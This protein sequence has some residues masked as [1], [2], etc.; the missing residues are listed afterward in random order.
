[1]S[2]KPGHFSAEKESW[3]MGGYELSGS[4]FDALL[5]KG[6]YFVAE[7][8]TYG[9]FIIPSRPIAGR[10]YDEDTLRNLPLAERDRVAERR[11]LNSLN[12]YRSLTIWN[13][14]LNPPD[15]AVS[16]EDVLKITQASINQINKWLGM[17]MPEKAQQTIEK[18]SIDELNLPSEYLDGTETLTRGVIEA[19]VEE[20]ENETFTRYEDRNADDVDNLIADLGDEYARDLIVSGIGPDEMERFLR[21]NLFYNWEI[22]PKNNKAN[23]V[24]IPA[25]AGTDL[26]VMRSTGF[27]VLRRV[28]ENLDSNA[29][30][31]TH[32]DIF[33]AALNAGIDNNRISPYVRSALMMDQADVSDA[34]KQNEAQIILDYLGISPRIAATTLGTA[35][36]VEIVDMIGDR[37]TSDFNENLKPYID[38]IRISGNTDTLLANLATVTIA[39]EGMER[40]PSD[41]YPILGAGYVIDQDIYDAFQDSNWN[42]NESIS[43]NLNR[44]VK[45]TSVSVNG[46]STVFNLSKDINW[47]PFMEGDRYTRK[48]I[49][50]QARKAQDEI[51]S[52][53]SKTDAGQNYTVNLAEEGTSVKD[54]YEAFREWINAI[55]EN[56]EN[57]VA[58]LQDNLQGTESMD[59]KEKISDST[60]GWQNRKAYAVEYFSRIEDI[61]DGGGPL[62]ADIEAISSFA[63]MDNYNSFQEMLN[64]AAFEEAVIEAWKKN[65]YE[66]PIDP[67]DYD[68]RVKRQELLDD[69]VNNELANTFDGSWAAWQNVEEEDKEDLYALMYENRYGSRREALDDP[70]FIAAAQTMISR[71]ASK[72]ATTQAEKFVS[73]I[74]PNIEARFRE[75]GII[76]ANTSPEFYDFL[77]SNVIPDIA[78]QAEIAGISDNTSLE[79]LIS[80]T[81]GSSP[82]EYNA[83]MARMDPSGPPT[84]PG[85]QGDAPSRRVPEPEPAPA[86]DLRGMTPALL[87]IAEERPEYATWLQ[88]QMQGQE[89]QQAWDAASRPARTFDEEQYEEEMGLSDEERAAGI[90]APG[91]GIDYMATFPG[92]PGQI[93]S[94]WVTDEE[95][96]AEAPPVEYPEFEGR[97]A[98]DQP[99]APA[100]APAPPPAEI[101]P[102]DETPQEKHDREQAARSPKERLSILMGGAR[103]RA[104]TVT[105]GMTQEEFFESRLPGFEDQ[106]KLTGAFQE[107]E[108]RRLRERRRLL[109]TGRGGGGRAFSVFRR[110]RR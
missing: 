75:A 54:G 65:Q 56:G 1:M 82:V 50:G 22:N 77:T 72:L 105:P 78:L 86:F 51:I 15:R 104:T 80:E 93:P 99:E 74:S 68:D 92:S 57:L 38:D 87:E 95:P 91:A 39:D 60:T 13:A 30:I 5:G 36:P 33:W 27:D 84:A 35:D 19:R 102:P 10:T 18:F 58:S 90:T 26:G 70:A 103:D 34:Q 64:D 85:M 79:K 94:P 63:I 23:K 44:I 67:K 109:A 45:D 4:T 62:E 42:F 41:I 97:P 108:N 81:I 73:N 43:E 8:D 96:A 3:N 47:N 48:D 53:V 107:A 76:S 40:D 49:K 46:E 69:I 31:M 106:F 24:E 59:W 37:W 71:G 88:G 25:P 12:M 14:V 89:F 32:Q 11:L 21:D 66:G 16:Y 61:V 17:G 98:S 7:G 20:L 28:S 9:T 52:N 83:F 2:H 101:I 29:S 100:E 55:G 110:G 6:M